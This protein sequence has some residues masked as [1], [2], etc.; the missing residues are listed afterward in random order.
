MKEEITLLGRE[1]MVSGEVDHKNS[2]LSTQ[3]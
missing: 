2:K 3:K 1:Y